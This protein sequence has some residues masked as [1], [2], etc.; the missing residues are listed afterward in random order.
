[1]FSDEQIAYFKEYILLKNSGDDVARISSSLF[2]SKISLNPHQVNAALAFFKNPKKKGMIFADEVGLGKTIEAGLVI[3]Q[4]WYE[5]KHHILII[6]PASLIKQWNEEL[7]EKFHLESTILDGKTV[8]DSSFVWD[9]GIY[10]TSV[11]TVYLNKEKFGIKFDLIVIDEAHKL[12][13]VYKDKGVMAPAIKEVFRGQKK[14]LLTATPF[15]N[16]LQELF[17][18]M[19]LID[20]D[21]FPDFA[22]FK[23]KYIK[24]YADNK[25]SLNSIVSNYAIRTLRK[26]VVKYINY[27]K[28]NVLLANY[29]L[30][31]S[32]KEIYNRIEELI[33]SQDMYIV[34]GT[35]QLHLI[36][37]LL[38]K[39]LSSSIY[40]VRSTLSN[41]KYRLENGK[42]V[43]IVFN[44][45]DDDDIIVMSTDVKISDKFIGNIDECVAFIDSV[46]HDSKLE[47][48]KGA[49]ADIYEQLET[50]KT[51]NRKILIF[52]ESK[53]T[54]E[55]LFRELSSIYDKILLFNGENTG[56]QINDIYA[57]WSTEHN[58]NKKIAKNIAIRRAI[59]DAFERDYEIMI[60]TDAAAEG[61]NL[62]FCS[63]IVNYDLP[64]NPQKIEQRIGRCH[65][66]GQKND[67]IVINMLNDSSNIDKRIYEILSGKLGVFEETFGS[68]DKILG[69]TNLSENIEDAIRNIY[70]SCRSPEEIEKGFEE[71]Q[72]TFKEEIESAIRA[73]E[74]DLDTFF[75][76]EVAKA[77]DFQYVEA[78]RIVDEMADLFYCIIK[79]CL[80]NAIFNYEE[81]SFINDGICR[82]VLSKYDDKA[83]F[84]SIS[85]DFGKK[86]LDSIESYNLNEVNVLELDYSNSGRK[87]GF[88]DDVSQRRGHICVSKIT[89]ESFETCESLVLTGQFDDGT[90]IPEDVCH[91]ILKLVCSANRGLSTQAFNIQLKLRHDSDV[92]DRITSISEYN[93]NIFQE[94]L[95]YINNWADSMIEKVQL[96]VKNMRDERKEL[97]MTCDFT[98]S[99]DEKARIQEQIHKLSKKINKSWVE[100]AQLEDEIEDRRYKLINNLKAEKDKSVSVKKI[101]EVELIIH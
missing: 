68:S 13:N 74:N 45:E 27:T 58:V 29:E 70:K 4:Y 66:Y 9:T 44:G 57:K 34:Y 81:Y 79:Q 95:E 65:R 38:Q 96:S 69:S 47:K 78:T 3:S 87:I 52:T 16:N 20:E 71:L 59:V 98:N 61:L 18:L 32:E 62:Q 31:D 76:E 15:Q 22:V 91:K 17:G 48:L 100:L 51:R 39:L 33:Y 14:L 88:L 93:A 90:I 94:E 67:V 2:D 80:P 37:L 5:Q 46:K 11:N 85:S 97:Q 21:I 60:A 26:D 25:E 19:S 28:R 30:L 89:Y 64:W 42:R 92:K 12:R 43:D 101:F 54:Q 49:I 7:M 53:K 55:Y 99:V 82:T 10:I 1:M 75:D 24:E 50:D 56:I 63:V 84:C 73:S 8:K 6:C 40:A 83:E 36:I 77:F 72:N 41:I 86:I 23:E 35:A